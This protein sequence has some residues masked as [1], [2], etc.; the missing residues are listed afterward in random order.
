MKNV[1][2]TI[3]ESDVHNKRSNEIEGA[4]TL[5]QT[6]AAQST[7][8]LMPPARHQYC[9][10]QGNCVSRDLVC[11]FPFTLFL[12]QAV[13]ERW[14]IISQEYV[15]LYYIYAN[16]V[17]RM[18]CYEKNIKWPENSSMHAKFNFINVYLQ[19]PQILQEFCQNPCFFFCL[20]LLS[21][22]SCVV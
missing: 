14:C 20:A 18:L 7:N 21:G 9:C 19:F 12:G 1:V 6:V 15:I 3:R 11:S 16:D 22:L 5:R 2:N 4:I 8:I 10:K 17:L 13:C